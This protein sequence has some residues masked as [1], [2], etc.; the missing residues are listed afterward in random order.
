MAWI[1]TVIVL[2]VTVLMLVRATAFC[3]RLIG[4]IRRECLDFMIPLSERHLRRRLSEWVRHYN[5]G[6][7]RNGCCE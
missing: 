6:R 5:A 3:E 7:P 2:V 4:T 1:K